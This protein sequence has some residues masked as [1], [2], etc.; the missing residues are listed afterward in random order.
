MLCPTVALTR[1]SL[2]EVPLL[3]SLCG[4]PRCIYPTEAPSASPALTPFSFAHLSLNF[5]D[6]RHEDQALIGRREA[7]AGGGDDSPLG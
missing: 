3:L 7:R 5:P 1:E 4:C 2:I 6:H